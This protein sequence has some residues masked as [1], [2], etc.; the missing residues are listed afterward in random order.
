MAKRLTVSL[1]ETL[2]QALEEAPSRLNLN[3]AT[4]ASERL[5]EYAR[6][7]YSLT[8]RPATSRD[9]STDPR[10]ASPSAPINSQG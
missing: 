2:E 8:V 3:A 5:R 4:S 7:G 6:R 9:R 1:D 10:A